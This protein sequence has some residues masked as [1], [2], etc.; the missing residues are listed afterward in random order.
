MI[1][2]FPDETE[3]IRQGD[4]F[5]NLPRIDFSLSEI[6]LVNENSQRLVQWIDIVTN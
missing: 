4:I 1:Y 3:P 2:E 5:V 6:I